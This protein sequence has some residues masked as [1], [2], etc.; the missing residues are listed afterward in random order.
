MLVFDVRCEVL[1]PIQVADAKGSDVTI[2]P[3]RYRLQGMEH[4]VRKAAGP[5][6]ATG[7]DITFVTETDG[8]AAYVVSA[9][10]LAHFI[11]SDEVE[12]KI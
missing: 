7:M 4:L 11:A 12:V 2:A 6:G 5:K 1:D 10:N 8:K 9:E 3:G